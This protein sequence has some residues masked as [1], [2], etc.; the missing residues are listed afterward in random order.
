MTRAGVGALVAIALTAG[1]ALR[2]ARLDTR[3][4]HNDEANQAIKF[5]TLL[6]HGEYRY[7]AYDHHGPTLYY[8]SLPAAWL[9]GQATLASLD[10]H[11]LRG[12][13]AVVGTATILLLP[14]LSAGIGRTAVATS[15]WLLALSPAM[16]FYSRMYIQESLFACFTLAFVIALGRVAMGGSLAW[17]TLAG[18]AAGLAVAT[19]ET[20]V[21][22]LPVAMGACAISWWS[23]GP[24]QPMAP[25]ADGRWQRAALVSLA[26]AAAVAALFYS[27]FLANPGGVLEPFRAAGTYLDRGLDPA[28][29]VHPWHYYL[30]LLAYSS[31]GGLRW[32]EGLVLGLAAVGAVTAW[33]RD[34]WAR[35]LTCNVAISAAIFS[36][37]RYKTPWNLL[38]F[39]VGAIVLAGIG[40]SALVHATS[41]RA[42]RGAL[43]VALVIASGQLGGQ[44]WRASVTYASDPRNPYVYAQTVPDAVR[45]ATRIRELAAVHPDGAR[46]QVSVIAAPHEQW[47]LPWYLRAMP[48]VGYWTAPGDALALQA[49]VV[50]ASMDH[51]AALDGALGDRYVSEFFGL[52]PEVLLTLYIERGLWERFLARASMR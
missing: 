30:G 15:A 24:G 8:L 51:T 12:V 1:L 5:G 20:S 42:V 7:D 44:A 29:H 9:R 35:Y 22:V 23:L 17:A 2:V 11:T 48:L 52:R 49:P 27:S 6:E 31:S 3:P 13:T 10:E 16:V 4:M 37:I 39:Y 47:P 36:A 38:P 25:L 28:D 19:K 18:V 46:M 33:K 26:V 32:S 40:F 21:I 45:M 41:S 50:V 34:F 14:L 43:A